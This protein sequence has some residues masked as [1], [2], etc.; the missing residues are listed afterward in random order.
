MNRRNYN[1][2]YYTKCYLGRW[3]ALEPEQPSTHGRIWR[4]TRTLMTISM[5]RTC[6]QMCTLIRTQI[7]GKERRLYYYDSK[8]SFIVGTTGYINNS[9]DNNHPFSSYGIYDSKGVTHIYVYVFS[10]IAV[11]SRTRNWYRHYTILKNQSILM[12]SL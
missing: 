6:L 4:E 11:G 9:S 2:R 12:Q 5:Q 7:P 8:A 1:P 10:N 3:L